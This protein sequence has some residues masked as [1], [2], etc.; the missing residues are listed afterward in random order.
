MSSLVVVNIFSII[1]LLFTIYLAKRHLSGSRQNRYYITAAAFTFFQLIL[2]IISSLIEHHNASWLLVIHL[3]VNTLHYTITPAIAVII[4]W[5]LG[6]SELSLKRKGLILIPWF[7]N[8]VFSIL[9]IQTGWYFSVNAENVY[10][11]GPYAY[12]VTISAYFYYILVFVQLYRAR[13]TEIGP[14]KLLLISVFLLPI[15]ATVLKFVNTNSNYVMGTIAIS[16][17]LY[18]L[19]TQEAKFDYDLQTMAR[20][21]VAFE[22]ELNTLRN[23]KPVCLFIFDL[24]NLKLTNDTWGHQE[25]DFLLST[26]SDLLTKTFEPAG[27]V[28]RIGGDEFCVILPIQKKIHPKSFSNH[29]EK[30]LQKINLTLAHPINVAWG[31]ALTN[32]K[33]GINA[34]KTF[35]LADEA[36][37]EHKAKLKSQLQ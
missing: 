2:E 9:S 8:A 19:I 36:M 29:F 30:E 34:N 25:G 13:A 27:K 10:M 4:L 12:G 31:Y 33:Q 32:E 7:I 17:L 24:N 14:A 22:R 18:Y 15:V 23:T 35:V 20:N 21:R 28:Y 6:Y 37:Y 11:Q 1:P 16:L 3:L 5:Y 26:L